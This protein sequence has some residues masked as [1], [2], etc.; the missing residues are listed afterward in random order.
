M[1]KCVQAEE[2]MTRLLLQLGKFV[3]WARGPE[4]RQRAGILRDA[5]MV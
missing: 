5:C 1:S 2:A 4:S 3:R